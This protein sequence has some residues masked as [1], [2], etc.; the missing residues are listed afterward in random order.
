MDGNAQ[1]PLVKE[2]QAGCDS[3]SGAPSMGS[4][5]GIDEQ[6]HTRLTDPSW[7]SNWVKSTTGLHKGWDW[8]RNEKV[9]LKLTWHQSE[10]VP[11]RG[12]TLHISSGLHT[13][14]VWLPSGV[15]ENAQ[16]SLKMNH[17]RIYI[18]ETRHPIHWLLV[19]L[20]SRKGTR[21]IVCDENE[22]SWKVNKWMSSRSRLFK[23]GTSL[24]VSCL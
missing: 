17:K 1:T 18:G 12:V 21:L 5:L 24:R 19:V 2:G 20:L 11:T 23:S 10:V 13:Q 7:R 22:T 4:I 9:L 6:R 8:C 15:W 16:I 14:Y 3:R